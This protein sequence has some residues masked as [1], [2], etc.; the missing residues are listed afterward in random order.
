MEPD[1][2]ERV[3]ISFAIEDAN[4]RTMLVGQAKADHTPFEL[5]DMSVKQPWDV[6]WKTQ[7]RTRIRG[8]KAMIGIITANT[9]RADGQIWELKCAYEERK[10]V[11]LMYGNNGRPMVPLPPPIAGKMI[12]EW[13][14]STIAQFLARLG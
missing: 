5:I 6:N 7:C 2:A 1:M 13:R 12:Y 3:F 14:W 8:C 11:F 4:L 10:P 9:P